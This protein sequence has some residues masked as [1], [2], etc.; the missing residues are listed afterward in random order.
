MSSAISSEWPG[1]T[2]TIVQLH[3]LTEPGWIEFAFDRPA[4]VVISDEVGGRCDLR[5]E[6]STLGD[7]SFL[8]L[9]HASHLAAN[10]AFSVH[11]KEIRCATLV[12]CLASEPTNEDEAIALAAVSAA[13]TRLMMKNRLLHDCAVLF[14]QPHAVDPNE[15]F[16]GAIART[17]LMAWAAAIVR[18]PSSRGQA[19][20]VAQLQSVLQ[21]I[22]DE[23]DAP[24]AVAA[25]AERAGVAP[26]MFTKQFEESTGM[27][28]QAW[29]MDV[30]V[31]NAQR[32]M[33]DDPKGSLEEFA[34]LC[35]FAD[36]SHFS[37]VFLKVTGLS[38]TEWLRRQT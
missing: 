35:G 18:K 7:G 31:R 30:R 11:A 38:P 17:V 15:P 5:L 36:Q 9:D 12:C 4:C 3:W 16:A 29:Q 24:I 14:G 22:R 1:L 10:T 6:H 20:Q 25:L 2:R 21:F 26:M 8:G 13:P 32:L 27:S 33:V 19:L 34:R 37:R 23:L 28:P